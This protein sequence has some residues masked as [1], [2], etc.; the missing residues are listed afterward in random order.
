MVRYGF[1]GGVSLGG[2]K[3]LQMQ[4]SSPRL[5]RLKGLH[6]LFLKSDWT[7]RRG[8]EFRYFGL[9]S[10]PWLPATLPSPAL[11]VTIITPEGTKI[12]HLPAIRRKKGPAGEKTD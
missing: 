12:I 7:Y 11:K 1:Y 9:E 6:P 2:P 4:Q 10:P 8:K 3:N 5:L